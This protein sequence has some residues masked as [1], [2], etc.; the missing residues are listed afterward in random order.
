MKLIGT[1][2]KAKGMKGTHYVCY[3]ID[4]WEI[5]SVEQCGESER[6][7]KRAHMPFIGRNRSG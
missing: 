7:G 4:I 2:A 6:E 1:L 3:N 5:A